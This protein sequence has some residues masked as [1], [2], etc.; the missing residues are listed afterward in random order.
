MTRGAVSSTAEARPLRFKLEV[1]RDFEERIRCEE[2]LVQGE[3]WRRRCA[4]ELPPNDGKRTV[5]GGIAP[6]SVE[7]AGD[8][9][10]PWAASHDDLAGDAAQ[11]RSRRYGRFGWVELGRVE[12]LFLEKW[13]PEQISGHLRRRGELQISRET[14]YRH[15]W[16]NLTR[17]G[18]CTPTC[19][20]KPSSNAAKGMDALIETKGYKVD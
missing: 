11:R 19:G 16:R 4:H 18:S 14:M 5:D 10:S 1:Q 7:P 3:H 9:G 13:S 20:A 6:S 2:E 12:A 17:G 8:R 15:V